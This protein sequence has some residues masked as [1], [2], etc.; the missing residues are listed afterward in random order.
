MHAAD[1]ADSSAKLL[2]LNT[3]SSA[4]SSASSTDAT[5]ANPLYSYQYQGIYII[6]SKGKQVRLFD[7]TDGV[8]GSETLLYGDF[9]Q[10]GADDIVYR[11]GNSLYLKTN[12]DTT[13][14]K[15]P[16]TASVETKS[17]TDF[18]SLATD[19]APIHPAPNFFQESFVASNEI[20]FSFSPANQAKDNLFRFEYYDYIDRFDKIAS[21]E[22]APQ[23][24]PTTS[25]HKTDLIP[26]LP[27]ETVV[28]TSI[29]GF[30]IRKNIA[31][32]AGG[33][34]E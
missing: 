17:W 33:T 31:S 18:L 24:A 32:F 30:I 27:S 19:N 21:G 15:A 3:D 34:G 14:T 22:Q 1:Y 6:D 13:I 25:I 9:T 8:D 7:Y 5:A 12:R 23:I 16:N 29:Q 4:P 26:D 2:A 10:N 11:M 20:D 28:D